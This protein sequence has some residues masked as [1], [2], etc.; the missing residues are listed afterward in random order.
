MTVADAANQP[1]LGVMVADAAIPPDLSVSLGLDD[2]L[3]VTSSDLLLASAS[4]VGGNGSGSLVDLDGTLTGPPRPLMSSSPTRLPSS[5]FVP[6][7]SPAQ[8]A[9]TPAEYVWDNGKS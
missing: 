5:S 2:T 8:P 3:D 1:D 7:L 4:G 6:T 9:S